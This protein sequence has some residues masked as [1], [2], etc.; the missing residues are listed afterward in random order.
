MTAPNPLLKV[1]SLTI[2]FGGLLAV[3]NVS[4]MVNNREILGII[5]PN[6][7]GKTTTFN[8]IAG[9][10]RVTSGQ[11]KIDDVSIVGRSPERVARAGIART[12]QTVR[13]FGELSVEENITIAA[14]TVEPSMTA[15]RNK[16]R[17]VADKLSITELLDANV[18]ELPL[19]LQKKVEI[20]R[21]LA[22]SPRVLLLDE[23]M[24][25]LT[26]TETSEIIS[27][28]KGLNADG[29]TI[30]VIEHVIRVIIELADRVLVLDHGE[31]IA[32][33]EPRQVMRDKNVVRAYLGVSA[34]RQFEEPD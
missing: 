31:L 33:G 11:I 15:A 7:A 27:V 29:L 22:L 17:A 3:N 13:L 1:S 34:A 19:A 9:A 32:E 10:Q 25:G 8:A 12:F 14:S 24:S 4:F 20:A 6:G 28:I 18:S 21:G 23:M 2:R 30:V 5:G 26:A 16:A